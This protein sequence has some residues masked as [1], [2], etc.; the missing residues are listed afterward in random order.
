M[1][2]IRNNRW[3]I[4][5][6]IIL[7]VLW[8]LIWD[9]PKFHSEP[10]QTSV[11][12][13]KLLIKTYHDYNNQYFDGRLPSVVIDYELRN[14]DFMALTTVG[15]GG[16]FHI[17][18]NPFYVTAERTADLV[19][20]HEQCHVKNWGDNHGKKWRACMTSLDMRGA[21]REELIYSFQE[22]K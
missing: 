10:T 2:W 11:V 7:A 15:D 8:S 22:D 13:E 4:L 14:P 19:M 18:F 21:F 5:L 3:Q 16:E 17:S 20:L 12:N 9:L 1:N 6:T